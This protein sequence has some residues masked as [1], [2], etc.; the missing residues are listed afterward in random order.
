MGSGHEAREPPNT[1][2]TRTWKRNLVIRGERNKLYRHSLNKN[3]SSQPNRSRHY[4]VSSVRNSTYESL[5]LDTAF[6]AV[7]YMPQTHM[8]FFT[9]RHG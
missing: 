2:T 3:S 1:G 7:T 4:A 6:K 8:R 9:A 5:L